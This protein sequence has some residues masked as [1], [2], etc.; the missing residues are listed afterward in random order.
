MARTE[1]QKEADKRYKAKIQ[2][3]K[4]KIEVPKELRDRLK[5]R[6]EAEGIT[7]IELIEKLLNK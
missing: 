5:V 4:T 1:A 2:T 6:A 7:M 3:T